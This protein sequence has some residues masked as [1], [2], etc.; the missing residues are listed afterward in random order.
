MTAYAELQQLLLEIEAEMRAW[1]VWSATPPPASALQSIQPFAIDTLSFWQWVQWI[2]VPR[3][4]QMIEQHQ[5]L[6]PNSNM[7]P[8]AQEAVVNSGIKSSKLIDY[9]NSLDQLL[10]HSP[11]ASQ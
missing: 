4:Q 1:S 5:P 11:S 7:A 3:L 10:T 6:P 2:M 8:M 9:F